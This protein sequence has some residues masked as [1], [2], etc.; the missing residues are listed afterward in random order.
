ML[1]TAVLVFACL[2]VGLGVYLWVAG[3]VPWGAQ[4]FTSGVV[5]LL[6]TVLERWRYRNRNASIE[7]N[8]QRTG[9]RFIDPESGK[10]VEVLYN[11]KSGERR[12]QAIG[13]P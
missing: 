10:E 2:L 12:Y 11:P 7:G 9:E 13:G 1:R 6:A 5:L 8:W 4:I 3:A